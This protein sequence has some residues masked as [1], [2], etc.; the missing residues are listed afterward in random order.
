MNYGDSLSLSGR[1]AGNKYGRTPTRI[2]VGL[3]WLHVTKTPWCGPPEP[4][5]QMHGS[6]LC[7]PLPSSVC[8]AWPHNCSRTACNG[9]E[10]SARPLISL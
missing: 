3:D 7:W 8:S 9:P 4:R 1:E 6:Y 5:S 2:S 10:K